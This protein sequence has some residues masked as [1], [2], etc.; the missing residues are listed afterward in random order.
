MGMTSRGEP[1]APEELTVFVTDVVGR[2]K[3]IPSSAQSGASR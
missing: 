1:G 3:P 2:K